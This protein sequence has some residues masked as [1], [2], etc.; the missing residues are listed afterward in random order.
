MTEDEKK[1]VGKKPIKEN[2]NTEQS[3]ANPVETERHNSLGELREKIN[4]F[5]DHFK[6][7]IML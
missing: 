3:K 2:N 1:G 4:H 6:W 7:P 5:K